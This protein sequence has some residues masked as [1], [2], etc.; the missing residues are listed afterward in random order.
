[1]T[2]GVLNNLGKRSSFN[3]SN[4][5]GTAI[6]EM[7]AGLCRALA[8]VDVL[9]V[10]PLEFMN[11]WADNLDAQARAA[12]AGVGAISSGITGPITGT[13]SSNPSDVLP[14]MTSLQTR[15]QQILLQGNAIAF[16]NSQNYTPS[17]GVLS[18]DVILIGGGAGGAGGV[19]N[20][21]A[22]SRSAGGGGGG[23]GEVHTTIPASLL[24]QDGNGNFQP[25][26]ITIGAGGAAGG[27]GGQWGFPGG[28]TSFGPWLVAGGGQGGQTSLGTCGPGGAGGAG[29]IL[30]GAGGHGGP[31][32][33]GDVYPT[34]ANGGNSISSYS[35]NGGGGG[36]GGGAGF[37]GGNGGNGG[38]GGVSPGGAAG[39]PFGQAG[40]SPASIIAT[41]GGGGG[42]A[43]TGYDGGGNGAFPAGGGGG[44]GANATAAAPGGYGAAGIAY[45]IE[46]TS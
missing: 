10:H 46:R 20:I 13:A 24:P 22:G 6:D 1:M 32:G 34:A 37:T 45:V 18:I 43:L 42:G 2:T 44:G 29:M 14:A 35:L 21:V 25:I 9:G 28:A 38:Q 17:K 19:W 15:F 27:A 33:I 8:G 3:L 11:Q 39:S 26:A 23:G 5:V 30:G 7:L 36:G 31:A 4:Y 40:T 12:V 41:G 16:T